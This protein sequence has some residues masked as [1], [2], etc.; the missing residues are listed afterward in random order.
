M[1]KHMKPED[2]EKMRQAIGRRIRVSKVNSQQFG[3][4]VLLMLIV[5]TGIRHEESFRITKGDILFE[6]S[7]INI[8]RPAK[9]SRPRVLGVSY[10]LLE[11]L[12]VLC[13]ALSF[14]EPLATIAGMPSRVGKGTCLGADDLKALEKR[15]E[16]IKRLMRFDWANFRAEVFPEN[17]KRHLGIHSNR[18]SI[19]VGLLEGNVPLARVQR[20]LG[21]KSLK[22]TA[23]YLDYVD[24]N[25]VADLTQDVIFKRKVHS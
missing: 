25:E 24:Q 18:H 2:L 22:S 8:R 10:E 4:Y 12:K 19:A 13:G 16:T 14:D 6:D 1:N 20:V 11:Y 17:S 15:K 3:R 9:G 5:E 23:V 21:H 7:Q